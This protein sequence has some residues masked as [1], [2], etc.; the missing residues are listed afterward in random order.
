[1]QHTAFYNAFLGF[2]AK[3]WIA[4]LTNDP[5][6]TITN[7][8]E[9]INVPGLTNEMTFR[10]FINWAT[11]YLAN[12]EN[13][14]SKS[15]ALEVAK[16]GLEVFPD[17]PEMLFV[18]SHYTD[19]TSQEHLDYLF[20]ILDHEYKYKPVVFDYGTVYNNIAWHYT[21]QK[22]YTEG[23]PYALTAVKLNPENAYSW[24]TLGEIYFNLSK[25]KECIEAF[26]QCLKLDKD[27]YSSR[28]HTFIGN[29]L[30]KMGKK[31]E[32]QKE[33]NLAK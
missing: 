20:R 17:N 18:C 8:E 3:L 10:D 1:M 6:E 24:D 14:R 19:D 23:L 30:L 26:Q 22:N 32:A 5:I 21:L 11:A 4:R 13:P 12:G 29:C 15:K 9:I 28:A 16:K 2:T 27:E 7:Y 33:F 31:K 25:Y